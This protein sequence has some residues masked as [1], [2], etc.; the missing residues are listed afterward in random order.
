MKLVKCCSVAALL[1]AAVLSTMLVGRPDSAAAG[2]GLYRQYYSSYRYYPR[3]NYYY[4]YYYYKPYAS[5]SGY[6][7]HYCIHYPSTPQ[8]VYYYN[9]YNKT[10]WGRYDFENKGYS[11][12]AEKDR[13]GK[14][15]EI[16]ES[17]FPKP[18]EMPEIPEGEDGVRIEAPPNDAPTGEPPADAPTSAPAQQ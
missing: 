2:T 12:L 16:P 15:E 1:A 9:P 10:Y 4:R 17:A 3:Y 8:Y 18:G 5:Y 6:N 14:L 11:L 7:Y 13:K